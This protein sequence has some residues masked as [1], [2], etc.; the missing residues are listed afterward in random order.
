MENMFQEEFIFDEKDVHRAR[1]SLLKSL[2]ERDKK[3]DI[4]IKIFSNE[5]A[6]DVTFDQLR[7]VRV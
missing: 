5:M 2:L 1:F 4:I 3:I 6:Y 7:I